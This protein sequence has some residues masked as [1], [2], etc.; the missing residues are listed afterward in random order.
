MEQPRALKIQNFLIIFIGSKSPYIVYGMLGKLLT[1]H[2]D[3]CGNGSIRG[4]L[5]LR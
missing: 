3:L 2:K 1:R 4:S 5:S